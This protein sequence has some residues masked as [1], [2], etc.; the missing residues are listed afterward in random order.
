M[1]SQYYL[2]NGKQKFG[3]FNHDQVIDGIQ[4]GKISLF[5]YILNQQ[6]ND[7]MM[8]MQHPDFSE[9]LS[10]SHE[11]EPKSLTAILKDNSKH[12]KFGMESSYTAGGNKDLLLLSNEIVMS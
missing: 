1:P 3:P 9:V 7:W 11:R 12:Y 5:D 2:S 8:L 4:S 10:D 6:T